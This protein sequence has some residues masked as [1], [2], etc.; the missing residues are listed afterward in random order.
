MAEEKQGGRDGSI[1]TVID[2]LNEY[3]KIN[4]R[5]EAAD[6]AKA[7]AL[8]ADQVE[9]LALVLEQSGLVTVHYTL[10]GIQ[11]IA[12]K[13]KEEKK[14]GEEAKRE[15]ESKQLE[16]E[17]MKAGS[18]IAFMEKDL[19]RRIK[20]AEQLL[21]ELESK[22][23]FTESEFNNIKKEMHLILQQAAMFDEEIVKLVEKE[24]ELRAL[25][26]AFLKRLESVERRPRTA[27]Q[28]IP[29]KIINALKR[30][31]EKIRR[32]LGRAR[33]VKAVVPE[34]EAA[35]VAEKK[36]LVAKAAGR[37]TFSVEEELAALR[38]ALLV[39]PE[40]KPAAPKPV[41]PREALKRHFKQK[42]L[43]EIS[44]PSP[45]RKAA[46]RPAKK[47]RRRRK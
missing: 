46:K 19:T 35:P 21:H 24:D 41:A 28:S 3:V 38:K 44:K 22:E 39:P 31:F 25:V 10:G 36:K 16:L 47:T 20:K 34:K 23:T 15:D 26:Q 11:L 1:D 18:I 42:L 4:G 37:A 17:V 33:P 13:P 30:L 43:D 6:A 29:A 32:L 7:L 8:T 40:E 14:A 2:R 45:A 5:V 9:R 27:V 12:R